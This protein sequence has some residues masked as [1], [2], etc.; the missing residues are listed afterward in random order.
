M[1]YQS[2]QNIFLDSDLTPAA[3]IVAVFLCHRSTASGCCYPAVQTIADACSLSKRTIQRQLKELEGRGY[4]VMKERFLFGEQLTNRYYFTIPEKQYKASNGYLKEII[5]ED[6]D[7]LSWMDREEVY[8]KNPGYKAQMM[9]DI[10]H[11]QNLSSREKLAALYLTFHAD[12]E[13]MAYFDFF[14]MAEE[15][16][17]SSKRLNT[18]LHCLEKRKILHSM[19]KYHRGQ[20]IYLV[21]LKEIKTTLNPFYRPYYLFYLYHR[22]SLGKEDQSALKE[23]QTSIKQT[24]QDHG[25]QLPWFFILI[26]VRKT[27]SV[28]RRARAP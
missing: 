14:R 16:S 17:L 23:P 12:R 25:K 2:I 10:F 15:L 19:K 24:K 11:C 8:T 5:L 22:R 4:L 26:K 13:A 27:K 20:M 9:T 3:K 7:F 6:P 18:I 21:M 1:K 28:G